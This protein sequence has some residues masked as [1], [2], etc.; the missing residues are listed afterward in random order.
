MIHSKTLLPTLR[1][2]LVEPNVPVVHRDLSWLQFNERVLYESENSV[3]PLLER[4]KFLSITSTNID[5]FFMIRVSSLSR[6]MTLVQRKGNN[7]RWR[8]LRKIRNSVLETV[9]KFNVKQ[10]ESLDVLG[11]VLVHEGVRIIRDLKQDEE[12]FKLGH[13]VFQESIFPKLSAP[14]IFSLNTF[15]MLE[16]LQLAAVFKN[17]FIFV[18]PKSIPQ[19]F[20]VQIPNTSEHC[21]FFLDDLLMTYLSAAFRLDGGLGILRITRDGDFTVD[22]EEEDTESIPD[23][24]KTSVKT[25]EKGKPVRIQYTGDLYL[26]VLD[27]LMKFLKLKNDEI[28]S[29]AGSLCL[30]GLWSAVNH[31]PDEIKA[32]KVMSHSPLVPALINEFKLSENIFSVIRAR[33]ILLHHPYDSFDSFVKWIEAACND[34]KVTMIEQTIYRMDAISPVTELLKAAAMK[35]KIKVIIELRARFDEMNNLRLADELTKA[36][37]EVAFGFG[38]LK[39]HAKVTL[40]TRSEKNEKGEPITAHYTHLSTGNYNATTARLY[41][42]LAIITA[43]KDIGLDARVFFDEA[44]EGRVPTSFRKLI[45]A[46]S[47]L[48]RVITA[49]IDQEIEMAKQGKQ[50]RVV[51]KVNALVDI[52]VIEKLYHASQ[53]GVKVDLIVRGATSIVPGVKGLSENIRVISV[54]DRFLEHSRIYYFASSKKIYLSSADWMPRNFFSRLELAFPVLDQ[55]IYSYIEKVL[56]S[57]YLTDTVKARE[58]TP[59]GTWRKRTSQSRGN[60]IR[61]QFYFEELAKNGYKNTPLEIGD[62]Q[63][64]FLN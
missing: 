57:T 63:N 49:M 36:G 25:R 47:K 46:P 28:M 6:T 35:K 52:G 33:D 30:G 64:T 10:N 53:A 38:K 12:I 24:V 8:K 13:V 21:I 29:A 9:N 62:E 7:E 17:M 16:N 45:P 22:L 55:R 59:Q 54:V 56:I 23:I 39:L 14:Q 26:G 37:V 51:V 43:N 15:A 60:K 61:S 3:N 50:A 5:E 42:D 58:L 2:L 48:H 27:Q 18:I 44:L 19:S 41:T 20:L 31:L 1:S 40:V 11:E 34:P 4:A 32:K